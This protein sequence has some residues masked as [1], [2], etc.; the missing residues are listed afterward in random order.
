MISDRLQK[1]NC[2]L[3]SLS[4]KIDTTTAAGKL[5]FRM[6]AVLAEFE[7]DQISERVSTVVAHKRSKGERVGQVPFGYD[8]ACKAFS[9]V[10]QRECDPATLAEE[11]QPAPDRA[12]AEGAQHVEPCRRVRSD[13][14]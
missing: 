12:T 9:D 5:V 3:V 2:D 1:A 10:S 13:R 4:E 14:A 6:L 7:R 8:L 11:D